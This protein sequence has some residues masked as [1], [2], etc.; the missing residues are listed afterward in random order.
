MSDVEIR[1]ETDLIVDAASALERLSAALQKRHGQRFR[2]LEQRLHAL[3]DLQ[4]K[5]N[6]HPLDGTTFLATPPQEWIDILAE[7]ERLGVG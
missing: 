1:I 4:P 5:P 6:V 3:P 2:V 7:A